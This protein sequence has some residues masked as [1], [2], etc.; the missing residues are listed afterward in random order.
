MEVIEIILIKE[1]IQIFFIIIIIYF[2]L[3]AIII[4][5]HDKHC[6]Q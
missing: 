3:L 6:Y 1:Q 2:P 4:D 5:S